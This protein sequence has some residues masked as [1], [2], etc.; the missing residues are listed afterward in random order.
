MS[1]VHY[2]A[3][4]EKESDSDYCIYFPD[5]PGCVTA[6]DTVGEVL[7]NAEEALQFHI[8]G[9]IRHGQSVPEPSE[10]DPGAVEQEVGTLG[11][12][13]IRARLP[14][15]VRRINISVDE[16]LLAD[17]DA[18]ASARGYNRSAFIAEATRQ[19]MRDTGAIVEDMYAKPSRETLA[20]GRKSAAVAKR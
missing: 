2:M 7:A 10:P 15:R 20:T 9:L 6:G 18:A 14:G 5:V 3:V 4:L 8:D 17:I 11:I 12:A 16:T 19:F 1:T 13:I